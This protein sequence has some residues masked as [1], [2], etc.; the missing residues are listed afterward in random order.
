M[1]TRFGRTEL[2][3]A[4]ERSLRR[5]VHLQW[6]SIG[7]LLTATTLVYAVLGGSQAMKAAWI[8]D[9]LS[10]APPLAFLIAVRVSKRSPN[11]AH[12]YGFHRSVG[13]AHLVA[14]VA[15]V[16]MGSYLVLDSGLGLIGTEHPPIGVV[17]IFGHTVWL[18]WLMIAAMAYTI[19]PPVILGRMKMRLAEELHDKVLYADAAMNKA[20]WM[21]AVGAIVGVLGIGVEHLVVQLFGRVVVG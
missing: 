13:V 2:P 8:E 11:A 21:T 12:P 3:P 7:F 9:L 4:Q 18:G 1:T 20:D 17:Q 14:A 6:I 15:L 19:A 10:F 16:T 5:A